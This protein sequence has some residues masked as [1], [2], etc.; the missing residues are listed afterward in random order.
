M[1]HIRSL[2]FIIYSLS[3]SY[4]VAQVDSLRI[5]LDSLL[6]DPLFETTQV[7]MMVYDLDADSV[8]F[9]YQARQLMRPASTM[10]LVTAITALD[11]LGGSYEYQTRIFYTG[12]IADS[13]LTGN[14]YCVGGFDPSL[15][16]DDVAVIAESIRQAGITRIVG[17]IIGDK[18]MKEVLDYGE[19]WCWD[20]DN[21]SLSSL[22]INGK[23]D[24]ISQ[25]AQQLDKDSIFPDGPAEYA[26]LPKDAVLL[27]QR[28]HS[29]ED[30]LVP[31]MKDSNNLYAESMFYQ[32]GAATGARPAKSSHA[33]NAI[34]RT[35]HKAGITGSHYKI[36]DGSGLSL[37]NYVTPELLTKLL[38]Y[39]YRH[40]SI[41]RY[42]Y[43][44]LPVAG[45]D[46]T[47]KKR[48][49]D[50]P[51]Q[52]S[53]RAKTGTLTGISS[54]AGYAV[55]TNN[56]VLAFAIINQGVMKNDQGRNFQDKVCTAMCK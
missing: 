25:F 43:V 53:V 21:P 19:G 41:Y 29:L 5:K 16:T 30:V 33:R 24:F 51:A 55:A 3:F 26:A 9:Q 12:T 34:K 11:R 37:Y 14:L 38:V 52:I 48:M 13:T 54:L 46:G 39:A 47:L 40:P 17:N 22:L 27:C 50:T 18:Q 44:S 8:L 4:A 7:G 23:D 35:L 36:A 31:M 49:K 45:E 15:T 1:T 28:S 10:K 6:R 32:I 56:H 2:L 20:D 42:L